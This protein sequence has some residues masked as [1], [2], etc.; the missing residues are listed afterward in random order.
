MDT[1]ICFFIGHCD[2]PPDIAP[3]LDSAVERHIV[4]FGVGRFIVGHYGTF[5]SMAAGAVKR[6]KQ[7]HKG[8]ELLLLLPY[9]PAERL[10]EIEDGFDGTYYPEGME[11][12]PKRYAIAR[13]NEYVIRHVCDYLIC[14]ERYLATKTHD[15]VEIARVRAAKGGLRVENLAELL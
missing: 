7:R 9:H 11:T 8:V 6:V 10:I 14:Y 5:D 12:V 4:D 15:F 13:A 1:K 2:S 3:F